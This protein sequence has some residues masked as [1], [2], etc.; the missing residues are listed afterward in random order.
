MF[1]SLEGPTA[2]VGGGKK[3]E[4]CIMRIVERSV[5]HALAKV[6]AEPQLSRTNT[7]SPVHILDEYVC[8]FD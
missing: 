7:R 6:G 3:Q 8:R 1:P 4:K 2:A 5:L